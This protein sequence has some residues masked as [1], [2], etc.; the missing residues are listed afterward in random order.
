LI[1]LDNNAT[2]AIGAKVLEAML[3]FYLKWYGNPASNHP[4]G[5]EVKQHIDDSRNKVADLIN[6]KPN[7]II[8]TSG[9]TEAI[10]LALKGFALRNKQKGNHIITLQTEH[11]AVLD[12]CSYL[13]NNV[14]EITYLSVDKNG[15]VNLDD[16]KNALKPTT[17]LAAIMYA[18]NETGIIQ[19]ITEISTILK[20][21]GVT[22]FTDSAQAVGKIKVDVQQ[23]GM[24]MLS[25]SAHKFHGPKGIGALYIRRKGS[26]KPRIEAI[27]H[28]GG[29]EMGYRSGTLNVAGITGLAIACEI[30]SKSLYKNTSYTKE[31]RDYFEAQISAL[32]FISINANDATRLP[33]T[34]NVQF[35]GFDADAIIMGL[36]NIMVSTGSACTSNEI[37]PSHVLLAM[38]LSEAEAYSSIRFSFSKMNTTA[39]VDVT[40]EAIKVVTQNLRQNYTMSS[41]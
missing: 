34:S 19:P 5:L 29:H 37:K 12:V 35:K 18:N 27:Q 25:L 3:P 23:D 38:G 4:F 21:A 16:L 17:I 20:D 22:L 10:N 6:A 33:N 30:A 8:F 31:L 15:L 1:Y 24:D 41:V 26:N 40:V 13:E 39:E 11:K 14:F 32:D 2:T 36:D 7:E 28:G 9:A